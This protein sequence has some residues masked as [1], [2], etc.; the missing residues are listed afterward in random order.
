MADD[1]RCPMSP[2]VARSVFARADELLSDLAA[3]RATPAA[4]AAFLRPWFA[5]VADA[6]A[7]RVVATLQL[8]AEAEATDPFA[9]AVLKGARDALPHA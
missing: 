7:D 3:G 8:I 6:R 1:C 5:G 9:H 2:D 4:V